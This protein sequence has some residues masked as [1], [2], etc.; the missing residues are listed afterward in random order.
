MAKKPMC[1]QTWLWGTAVPAALL[2]L[3][4]V[5]AP[6][7]ALAQSAASFETPE[8]FA[9]GA[10]KQ[11]NASSAYAAGFTGKGV[12]VGVID[13]GIDL[14]NVEFAP[15]GKFAGGIKFATAFDPNAKDPKVYSAMPAGQNND[16]GSSDGSHGTVVSSLIAGAR[17]GSGMHGSAYDASLYV[18]VPKMIVGPDLDTQLGLSIANMVSNN[19]KIINL[20][21]GV[22]SCSPYGSTSAQNGGARCN[23]DD[24]SAADAAAQFPTLP[25]AAQAAV[26]KGTLLVFATG[27]EGQPSPDL[28]AGMPKVVDG[29]QNGWLA[30]GAVD[31]NNVITNYSNRCGSAA[32]WC[33]VA[34]GNL[35]G[36]VAVGTGD[37]SGT[38]VGADGTNY[39][40]GSGTSFAAPTVAGVA[41]LTKQAY[42]WFT[43][44][45]L[46]QTLLTTATPLGTR[47]A[48]SITPDAI[49]GW[50]LVNAGAAVKGYGGFVTMTTLD[51]QG[52]NSTFSN[53]I[54]GPGG[55]IKAGAGTLTL[56][57][58]NTYTDTTT[59]NGGSLAVTGSIVSQVTVAQGGSFGGSGQVGA[60]TINGTL[61]LGTPQTLTINGN[62]AFGATG[63][64]LASIQGAVSDLVKVNG[65]AALAGTLAPQTLGGTYTFNTPY[66][67]LSATGGVNGTFGTFDRSRVGAGLV[68]TVAY[69]GSS[70]QLTLTP[71]K[72]ATL[73][74][75]PPTAVTP[76]STTTSSG[77]TTTV[78]SAVTTPTPTNAVAKSDSAKVAVA[79]DTA[80]SQGANA[81]PLFA[82]YNSTDE[83]LDSELNQL[84]GEVHTSV[85][86]MGVRISSQFLGAMTDI[87][88]E[89]RDP[90]N[91]SASQALGYGPTPKPAGQAAIA[92]VTGTTAGV[93]TYGPKYSLWGGPITSY[94]TTSGDADLGTTRVTARSTQIV[95]GLDLRLD[96]T[97]LVGF[98]LA[99]GTA[100]SSLADGLG[101]ASAGLAQFGTYAST[102]MGALSLTG[103]GAFTWMDV[104]THRA[105]PILGLADVTG[106]Y[107]PTIWSGRL[108]AAYEVAKVSRVAFSPFAAFEAQSMRSPGFVEQD[109]FA[110][111]A[112]VG[113]LTVRG[114]TGATTRSILGLDVRG[115]LDIGQLTMQGFV[116]AGW[117]HYFDQATS[118]TAFLTGIPGS[119]FT[120][121]GSKSKPD[122]ATLALG[123]N[124]RI[125]PTLTLT[126]SFDS[127]FARNSQT[128]TGAARMRMA[129]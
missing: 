6:S 81:T 50:G 60:T 96:P 69:T 46:Q 112:A 128:Y 65:S 102:R 57:G 123:L 75:N 4:P 78:T 29:I 35:T 109:A 64:Y 22:N 19:V 73:A 2:T 118:S 104:T 129:F 26:A 122:A 61:G 43:N 74:E 44:Y 45:D 111:G 125:T 55:L 31:K 13:S 79:I 121:T 25:A 107:Q 53:D 124:T 70:V 49:Y 88:G 87:H 17:D 127:E 100:S 97:T 94:S 58:N 63:V 84:T 66:T 71:G 1:S 110:G 34:P 120:V 85:N 41:A 98:A 59:V 113:G 114:Q 32:E 126:T 89:G 86:R 23:V 9:S 14:R 38:L 15:P 105:I 20:S 36:A 101:S 92:N 27:N 116:R 33:L 82:L 103:A 108:E 16:T 30:V 8:Y 39:S 40:T 90:S 68:T 37:F 51:T 10:L 42:P 54:Y 91:P 48:G 99:G 76:T 3:F 18:A 56:A 5:L 62:L 28:L 83:V 52:Y 7:Q 77:G 47:T 93:P 106:R 95:G 72:L 12:T 117:G 119:D 67:V 24:Y 11:I 80:V 21:L 115:S